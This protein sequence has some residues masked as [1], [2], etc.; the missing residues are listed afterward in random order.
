VPKSDSSKILLGEPQD[1]NVD[2]GLALYNGQDVTVNVFSGTSALEPGSA[3]GK[4]ESIGKVLSPVTQKEA[5]AIRCIGLNVS[6]DRIQTEE[7]ELM[8]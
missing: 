5:G 7:M 2:V 8:G 4:T 3:T 1:E 6:L